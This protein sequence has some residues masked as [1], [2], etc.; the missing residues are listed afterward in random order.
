MIMFSNNRTKRRNLHPDICSISVL[1]FR[2][3]TQSLENIPCNN[4]L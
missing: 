1:Y 4:Y 3:I 2:K